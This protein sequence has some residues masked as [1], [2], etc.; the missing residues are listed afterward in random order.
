VRI[1]QLYPFPQEE[2]QLI[3]DKYSGARELVWCQEEPR[4]QGAW[5]FIQSR[6]NMKA[7]IR[8]GQILRYAGRSY[9]ASPASGSLHIHRE[10]QQALIEDAL[11]LREQA[12]RSSLRAV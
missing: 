6:R 8:E 3:I 10:Q 11:G 4:N 7:C 2:A 5:N 12:S 1:E 9:S